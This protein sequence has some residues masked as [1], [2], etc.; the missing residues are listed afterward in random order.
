M[1]INVVWQAFEPAGE[2]ELLADF[3]VANRWPY[4]GNPEPS[5]ETVLEWIA[6]GSFGNSA[7]TRRFWGRLKDGTAA[8][9]R[10]AFLA[11]R[12]LEDPTPVF[13]L[14]VAEAWRSRGAGRSALAFLA[15]WT[16]GE[17]EKLRIEAHTRADNAPMR[18]LLRAAG[19]VQEAHHRQAWPDR[20]GGWHD[21]V[22]YAL[23]R[24]DH[25]SGTR[26]PCPPLET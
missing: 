21:A 12:E 6:E 7:E 1:T 22:T 24:D 9:P 4:H 5:R 26:T 8:R 16:F 13:D 3:L 20:Q 10:V 17:A 19:W 15:D 18:A 25:V 2:T 14:R 23:L 11:L